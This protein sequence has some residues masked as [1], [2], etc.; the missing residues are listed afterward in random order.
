MTSAKDPKR[1]YHPETRMIHGTFHSVHWDYR[2]HI[3]PPISSSAAYRL[4]S[5]ER[6]A[7]GFLEFAN[8]EFNREEHPPIYIYDRLDEPT[9]SMLEE[10]LAHA[11]GA[12]C[13][14]CF[15]T[16]MA[17]ISAAL[18]VLVRSGD[19]ILAHR[20]LYGC[21]WSLLT[22]WL[23]R[24]GVESA[25]LDFRD[26]AA[27]R[28]AITDDVMAVYLET[29]ANPT[30]EIVDLAALR[31]L[32]DDVNAKRGKRRKVFIVVDNT[33]ATPFCQRPIEFGVDLVCHSLT[34]NIGGFGTDMGGVVVGPRLLEPDLLLFRKDFGAPLAPKSAWPP[35]VHGLPTLAVRSRRQME[36]AMIVARDLQRHAFVERV[37]YPGLESH[38]EYEV[39]RRQMRDP[40]GNFAP[41]IVISFVVRGAPEAAQRKARAAMNF[42]ADN[43]LSITLA[44]SLGQIRT[45]IEHPSS[46]THAPIP[47]ERQL[48]AGIEP[49]LVR[50]SIGLEPP[51]DIL[52]DL[53]EAFA[54]SGA[55]VAS[56]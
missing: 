13:G 8:P 41:G 15:S 50:L 45:L 17:A 24:F 42:L 9:R 29:P 4:E 3:V 40:D 54:L 36:T 25:M 53:H 26:L 19:R 33:F 38:P 30:L 51:E 16:G 23:P 11:E 28:N 2:D 27:L 5:A 34:K 37:I 35:L 18:G 43:S 10:A 56:K 46:M 44:V 39:A 55:D 32:V 31:R 1:V 22:N 14:V 12:E 6:G 20:S 52:R 47:V 7:T 48:E 49:G 21:T